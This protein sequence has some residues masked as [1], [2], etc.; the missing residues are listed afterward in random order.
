MK[1]RQMAIRPPQGERGGQR[2]ERTNERCSWCVIVTNWRLVPI[3]TTGFGLRLERRGSHSPDRIGEGIRWFGM[4]SCAAKKRPGNSGSL[5]QH[6]SGKGMAHSPNCRRKL[7]Y[8]NEANPPLAQSSHSC[9]GGG[10]FG[11]GVPIRKHN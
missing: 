3:K 8:Y 4:L 9:R 5:S 6:I 2:A 10:D 1:E 11:R 7:L